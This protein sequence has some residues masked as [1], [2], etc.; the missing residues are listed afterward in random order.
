MAEDENEYESYSLA[1]HVSYGG[2][3]SLLPLKRFKGRCNT[4][5]IFGFTLRPR[6]C[7]WS[8][9]PA[10]QALIDRILGLIE[11]GM[12]CRQI[13]TYL[14]EEGITSWGVKRFYPELVFVV[15]RKARL[16][17]ER[18]VGSITIAITCNL[19]NN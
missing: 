16:N 4:T 14:N 15:V 1:S 13:S 19:M 11:H 3:I 6:R 17:S 12:N 7:L 18:L 5:S 9:D 2:V 10:H 8:I